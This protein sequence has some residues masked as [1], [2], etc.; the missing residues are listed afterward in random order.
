[1]KVLPIHTELVLFSQRLT[2]LKSNQMWLLI[3]Q[4]LHKRL[5]L[6]LVQL[7][8]HQSFEFLQILHQSL[9]KV[10]TKMKKRLPIQY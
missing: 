8:Y 5:S 1:M 10:A 9:N 6:Y 4:S 2:S 3:H 7:E